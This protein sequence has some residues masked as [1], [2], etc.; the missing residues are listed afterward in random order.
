MTTINKLLALTILSLVALFSASQTTHAQVNTNRMMQ[1]GRNALYFEDY[2]LSIQYFNRVIIVKPYLADPYYYRAIAKFY[3]DDLTGCEA[4]CNVA[5]DINP[6]LIGAYN[7]R[8]ITHLRQDKPAAARDDFEKGLS[9][10]PENVNMLLNLGIANINLEEYDKAIQQYDKLLTI[11]KRNVPAIL[12][13]GIAYVEKGDTITALAEFERATKINAYSPEAFTYLGMIRYQKGDFQAALKCYDRLAEIRP[14]DPFVYVNRAITKYNL[15]D[16]R[17]CMA[18]LDEAIRLDPKNKLAFQN[19]GLLRAEAG[20][21]NQAAEDFSRALA[22][23]PSDDITLFNRAIVYGQ[24]GMPSR[25]LQDLNIIIAKHPDFGTA[26]AQRAIAKRQLGDNKGAEE[27]YYTAVTFEQEKSKRQPSAQ[28]TSDAEKADK[29]KREKK[30]SRG[31][32]DDDMKKYDQMVVVAD[33]GDTDDKLRQENKETIRGRVQ[34]R[35]IA[36]DLEPA[37]SLSFFNADT[38]LPNAPYYSPSVV[39][40]NA[41]GISDLKMVVT[42]RDVAADDVSAR[43]FTMI[44]GVNQRLEADPWDASLYILR[45]TLYSVVM[46]YN[47]AITD[48]SAAILKDPGN[49]VALFNRAATRYKMVET[50]RDMDY[51]AAA[52]FDG[53]LDAA[54]NIRQEV[55]FLDYDLVMQDL[56]KVAELEPENEF[57]YFNM[58]LVFCQR[59]EFEQALQLLDKAI[60]IYDQFAE[61]YFNRGIIKLYLGKEEEGVADLSRAGE[62]GMFKAYNVI[63]RFR[64]KS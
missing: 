39:K 6:F 28:Q 52:P 4:D 11:D 44:A 61:A 58:S 10:E 33:F 1:V 59:K 53:A 40:F 51:E 62:L 22:I 41:A 64:A 46:N 24:L 42:N 57:A 14:K 48:L 9:Y 27:D 29:P 7:L 5:I 31:K 25:A 32:N 16:L 3:L 63:K 36:I 15:D 60:G 45:G 34:D 56:Q 54:R 49:V 50:I 47:S 55:T 30:S 35:D 23:D 20:D 38:L 43:V 17:G 13:R 8:G 12:Y 18:D 21:L 2:V 26:Y 37:F 19:R